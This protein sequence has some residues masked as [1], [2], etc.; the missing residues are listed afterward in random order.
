MEL[1]IEEAF[2]K[3]QNQ[4]VIAIPTET[5][6]GL[7]AS[8]YSEK[9]IQ[10]IF[11]LK[12]R[13]LSNPLIIH[14]SNLEQIKDQIEL[15]D[16]T[17]LNLIQTFWPGPLTIIMK[18]KKTATLSNLITAG[19]NT[20]AIRMPQKSETLQLI[21]KTGPLVAPSANLSGYPS[22]TKREHVEKDFGLS[23]PILKG[24]PDCLGI[25]STII[26]QEQGFWKI[27]REGALLAGDLEKILGYKPS[28]LTKKEKPICPGQH[29]KHYSPK[30][31]LKLLPYQD[32]KSI[33]GVIIGFKERTYPLA[34]RVI[35]LGSIDSPL[36]CQKNLYALLRLLDDFGY[37]EAYVD[38]DFP[39][40]ERLQIIKRRIEKAA[41]TC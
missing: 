40:D 13:P 1:S 23:F 16:E 24:E 6:F 39:A 8:I 2:K 4:E 27:A 33:E 7:A 26:A 21:E 38:S 9:A 12:N 28:Q 25:E 22:S 20:V 30:A 14:I 3:L 11:K 36:N 29:F 35:D 34:K 41:M 18:L 5:V 15:L 37:Q 17:G 31:N 19:L 32:L 10:A